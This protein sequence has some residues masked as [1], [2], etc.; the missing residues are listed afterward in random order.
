MTE[1]TELEDGELD[2]EGLVHFVQRFFFPP[3]MAASVIKRIGEA[4]VQHG[5]ERAIERTEAASQLGE[6][7]S[8]VAFDRV[9]RLTQVRSRLA[10]VIKSTEIDDNKTRSA[11]ALR[12]KLREMQNGK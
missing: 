10:Y 3:T 6:M 1:R 12:S 2:D 5:I 4:T 9:E 7:D 8:R 11:N